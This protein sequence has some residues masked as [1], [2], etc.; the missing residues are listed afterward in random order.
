MEKLL[1]AIRETATVPQDVLYRVADG[2]ALWSTMVRDW[3]NP[4]GQV[5]LKFNEQNGA[6]SH[7]VRMLR[8]AIR[9]SENTSLRTRKKLGLMVLGCGDACREYKL[10]KQIYEQESL[11]YLKV[12]LV[13]LSYDLVIQ[14]TKEFSKLPPTKCDIKTVLLDLLDISN[15]GD[16]RKTFFDG[17]PVIALLLG[18]TL[19][20]VDEREMLSNISEALLPDDLF[21]AEVLIHKPTDLINSTGIESAESDPRAEFI[22][23]PVR[24]LVGGDP[25]T[26]ALHARVETQNNGHVVKKTYSYRFNEDEACTLKHGPTG[27]KERIRDGTMISLLEI[28]SMSEEYLLNIME[29]AFEDIQF[30]LHSYDLS[31]KEKVLLGYTCARRGLQSPSNVNSKNDSS[32]EINDWSNVSIGI[33]S[34][35]EMYLFRSRYEDGDKIRKRDGCRFKVAKGSQLYYLL[36]AIAQSRDASTLDMADIANLFFRDQIA[37][38]ISRSNYYWNEHNELTDIKSKSS[39]NYSP[40]FPNTI[41]K[42]VSRTISD[43]ARKLRDTLKKFGISFAPTTKPPILSTSWET[44]SVSSSPSIRFL[45]PN[46]EGNYYFRKPPAT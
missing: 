9:N 1:D 4:L 2:P 23:N 19:G 44:Q 41:R 20:N 26:D 10:C 46:D 21:L 15:L 37:A 5:F 40:D 45:L 33:S 38:E 36:E 16:F 30:H 24:L 31:N 11:D 29:I 17:M 3:N 27:R 42:N 39:H 13:D 18:N 43:L 7:L 28:K 25:R 14:A 8:D 35:D 6:C 22:A 12:G 32:F 34:W